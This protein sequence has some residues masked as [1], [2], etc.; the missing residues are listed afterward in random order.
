MSA[1]VKAIVAAV[2]AGL[3][4]AGSVIAAGHPDPAAWL[5]VAVAI[6][7]TFGGVYVAPANRTTT[8]APVADVM[9]GP[10]STTPTT[11]TTTPRP[12]QPRQ[13]GAL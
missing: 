13:P 6:V 1:Y 5:G 10:T 7:A 9:I 2:L 8:A 11:S 3:T 4:S 12:A